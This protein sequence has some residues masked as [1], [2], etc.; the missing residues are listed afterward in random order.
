MLDYQTHAEND[1]M[2]N[3]PPCWAIYVCGLVFDKLL[4]EGGLDAVQAKNQAK[5]KVLYEAIASGWL[6]RASSSCGCCSPGKEWRLLACQTAGERRQAGK[7]A[8]ACAAAAGRAGELR[9]QPLPCQSQ[10]S[11]AC[12]PGP[13]EPRPSPCPSALLLAFAHSPTRQ[14][15][16]APT[17]STAARSTPLCA[18]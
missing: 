14:P 2:Y 1:S 15:P 6:G 3:T 7:Q 16:Q 5:A 17:A 11:C 8:A 18:P 13:P 10:S 9:A 4:R 12:P